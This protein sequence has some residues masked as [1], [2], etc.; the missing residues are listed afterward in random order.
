MIVI[1]NM[2]G[3]FNSTK[4]VNKSKKPSYLAID[5]GTEFVKTALFTVEGQDI[6]IIGYSR[7]KQKESNMYAAFIISID[8]VADIVDKSIGEAIENAKS[9]FETSYA[10]PREAILGIA[11]EL[12]QGVTVLVNMDRDDPEREIS[13]REIDTL[14]QKVKAHTFES[15]KEDIALETGIKPSQVQ[16]ID[17]YINSVFIDGVRVTNPIGYKGSELVYRVFS[18]FAPKIHLD[19]LNRVVT[20]LGLKL[21]KVAVEPYAITL[22]LKDLR[23]NDSSGI[24]IDV[25]GGTTDVAL[26]QNGDIIG[27]KMF[28]IGGRVF[29]KRIQ[30][31]FGIEYEEAEQKKIQYTEGK[32]FENE[33]KVISK[34]FQQDIQVWLSGVEIALNEF[35][36]VG[37]YPSTIYLCGGGALLPEIQEGLLSHPW[38]QVLKFKKYPK[39]N[40]VFP[41]SINNVTD[42][43][44]SA[45]LP[46]DVA[47]LSLARMILVK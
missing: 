6:E 39:V 15:T 3:L 20:N 25:G 22:A 44:K 17:T 18:T 42:R 36:D 8:N 14:I 46:I 16:E 5:I 29:T 2:R 21:M 47:P 32:L 11:G 4:K 43:T 24:I 1:N 37:E 13:Q 12:V 27:T 9:Y 45:T 28:A 19:S 40:F 7:M 41:A 34:L 31:E 38:L 35:E 30:K 33:A 23:S 10:L 26:V